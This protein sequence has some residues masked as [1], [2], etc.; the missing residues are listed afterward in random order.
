VPRI[1]LRALLLYALPYKPSTS[2]MSVL[3]QPL[4]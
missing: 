3:A 2:T 1:L 4:R